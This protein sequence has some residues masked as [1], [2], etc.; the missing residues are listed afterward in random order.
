MNGTERTIGQILAEM[1]DARERGD[2]ER[3]REL[4]A[5]ARAIYDKMPPRKG[6]NLMPLLYA[7]DPL[8]R[9]RP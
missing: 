4:F 6:V 7:V 3:E 9:V 1:D 5:E 2:D 8:E